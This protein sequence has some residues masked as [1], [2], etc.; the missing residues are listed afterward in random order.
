MGIVQRTRPFF[1]F[2]A[3]GTMAT[4]ATTTLTNRP[5]TLEEDQAIAKP[6]T[7]KQKHTKNQR[8][9]A[10]VS[11]T[12]WR[13]TSASGCT[14]ARLVTRKK[15]LFIEGLKTVKL[16]YGL[17]QEKIIRYVQSG[18]HFGVQLC[19]IETPEKLKPTFEEFS[20]IFKNTMVSR[21]DIG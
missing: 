4:I 15:S 13:F 18:K 9:C 11:R 10:A 16:K 5:I 2:T 1:N 17:T 6:Q 14:S 7:C 20:P 8:I 12:C 21:H 3:A 19:N